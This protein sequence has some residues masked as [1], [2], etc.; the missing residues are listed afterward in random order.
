MSTLYPLNNNR[1]KTS[2]YIHPSSSEVLFIKEKQSSTS[3]APSSAEYNYI[4]LQNV[5][6][7]WT[8]NASE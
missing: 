7:T 2:F 4:P 6:N 5:M 1:S 8:R 3:D